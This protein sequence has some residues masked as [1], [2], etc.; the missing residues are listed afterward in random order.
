MEI[1]IPECGRQFT[2]WEDEDVTLILDSVPL[3]ESDIVLD[4]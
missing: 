2:S 1:R 4:D 3:R